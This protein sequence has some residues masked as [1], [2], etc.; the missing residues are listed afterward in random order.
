MGD[1]VVMPSDQATSSTPHEPRAALPAT[2]PDLLMF[3]I[4]LVRRAGEYTLGYF[5]S[6][7]LHV[8]T[9]ADG[10]PVTVADRGAER[11]MREAIE[12]AYPDDSIFGEEEEERH[13]TSGRRWVI[14]PIDGTMAFTAGVG[15]YTNLLYLDDGFGPAVG[16]I[17]VPVLGEIVA[18]GRGLGCTLNQV[19]CGVSDVS[20]VEGATLTTSGFE[21]WDP[22]ALMRTRESGL[23]MRTWGDGYGYALVASG[24][25][26]VMV[27]PVTS[28]WD[29]A[30][31]LVIIPEAGGRVSCLD[32]TLP[33]EPP[34]FVAT[35]GRIHDEVLSVLEPSLP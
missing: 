4:D 7:R 13:G 31:C 9:K 1:N 23:L 3:A 29:I 19:A 32:G 30:P 11:L 18:A 6:A 22:D 27:D 17:G 12:V 28:F 16:V 10:S 24:R 20:Q 5:G 14:D 33:A 26:E 8:E 25:V 2:D 35:N 21:Y 15:T 34:N